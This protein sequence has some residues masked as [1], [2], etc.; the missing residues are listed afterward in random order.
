MSGKLLH[1]GYSG[2]ICYCLGKRAAE[3]RLLRRPL[4]A[5]SG[6]LLGE[7]QQPGAYWRARCTGEKNCV[8]WC[9]LSL[10]Q[11]LSWDWWGEADWLKLNADRFVLD[12]W[13]QLLAL[14]VRE[15][16]TRAG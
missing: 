14:I 1:L 8:T 11:G 15:N 12:G 4:G 5:V 9:G 16:S 6:I 2:V 13:L 10:V 3:S 7:E